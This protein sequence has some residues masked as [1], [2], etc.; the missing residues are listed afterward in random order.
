MFAK[1]L[2]IFSV[3]FLSFSNIYCMNNEENEPEAK[4]LHSEEHIS[5]APKSLLEMCITKVHQFSCNNPVEGIGALQSL[6]PEVALRV[7]QKKDRNGNTLLHT[8]AYLGNVNSVTSLLNLGV[9]KR[10]YNKWRE[11]PLMVA[12]KLG[13]T[14]VCK[15]LFTED[16][17]ID[18]KDCLTLRKLFLALPQEQSSGFINKIDEW[19]YKPVPQMT[20]IFEPYVSFAVDSNYLKKQLEDSYAAN[21]NFQGNRGN[22]VKFGERCLLDAIRAGNY[23]NV[24]IVLEHNDEHQFSV[25]VMEGGRW[26]SR[27]YDFLYEATLL[28]HTEIVKLLLD[29][30]MRSEK[31]ILHCAVRNNNLE[32]T[33]I[34][35]K[36]F[37]D[38]LEEG[39]CRNRTPL[40][41]AASL[42]F[43]EVAKYLL[44]DEADFDFQDAYGYSPLR[45]ALVN[46]HVPLVELLISFGADVNED[47]NEDCDKNDVD[48]LLKDAL[49]LN[50]SD[51][52]LVLLDKGAYEEEIY[53]SSMEYEALSNEIKERLQKSEVKISVL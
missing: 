37:P 7:A 38:L 50:N 46:N 39:D 47:L 29:Y 48:S 3:V 10:V 49:R 19:V 18:E 22:Y 17:L 34:Y 31:D 44:E 42:G 36:L 1:K 28:N 40:F 2:L 6:A 52:I 25:K 24:Q 33:K 51:L 41:Y 30:E 43:Y 12:A 32:L 20:Q 4:R 26:F 21:S 23:D 35:C 8:T 5:F 15:L 27:N 11:T 13:H 9:F 16:D 14:E 45:V 53:L